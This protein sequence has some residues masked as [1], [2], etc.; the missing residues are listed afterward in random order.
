MITKIIKALKENNIDT[1]RINCTQ[2]K[3]VELFFIKPT[4]FT[5]IHIK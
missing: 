1:Y 4:A 2:S 3:S 5:A